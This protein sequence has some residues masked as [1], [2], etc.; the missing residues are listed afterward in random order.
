MNTNAVKAETALPGDLDTLKALWLECFE[1]PGDLFLDS[2][3]DKCLP[4]ICRVDGRPVSM[5]YLLPC[6][7]EER[8][9]WYLYG[10]AT[11]TAYRKR[12]LMAALMEK[13]TAEMDARGL[14]GIILLPAHD[15]LYPFY[16]KLGFRAAFVQKRARVSR[17]RLKSL[18][19]PGE[20]GFL[21]CEEMETIRARFFQQPAVLFPAW[22]LCFAKKLYRIFGG[23]LI[24]AG[25]AYLLYD[26]QDKSILIKEFAGTRED[27]Y[28]LAGILLSKTD[29]AE[30]ILEL[31]VQTR[32]PLEAEPEPHG[33]LLSRRGHRQGYLSFALD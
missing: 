10:A 8:D 6:R 30:Y 29:A 27:F 18:S 31:P 32:L 9:Y 22:Y 21:S 17:E 24:S 11:A 15:G 7:M 3:F 2:C 1:E 25:Q 16:E 33:M 13:A 23:G 20:E 19:L 5:L 14:E 4:L 26:K 28:R 12:G